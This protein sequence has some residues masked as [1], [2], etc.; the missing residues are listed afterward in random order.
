M[1]DLGQP[2]GKQT[3]R[4]AKGQRS[5]ATA[6][7][8]RWP[9]VLVVLFLLFGGAISLAAAAGFFWWRH[10]QTTPQYALAVM[11]DAAQRNDVVTLNQHLNETDITTNVSTRV[12]EKAFN[13]YGATLTPEMKRLAD[14]MMLSAL[15]QFQQPVHDAIVKAIKDLAS[16]SPKQPFFIV[17]LAIPRF[18]NVVSAN[19]TAQV[20]A[21]VQ[22]KKIDLEMK[23]DGS[24]WKIVDMNDDALTEQIVDNV[25]RQLPAI[26][27]LD[28]LD[29]RIRKHGKASQ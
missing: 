27:T 11:M 20:T 10:Y 13:R 15:P 26:G 23:H 2:A 5:S 7:K 4:P 29:K 1:I 12:K 19:D 25:I 21:T 17:A 18:V 16:Q 9:T 22:G 3:G 24:Q 14:S 28:T 8:R 6:K